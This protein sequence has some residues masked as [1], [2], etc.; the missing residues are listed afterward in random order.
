M[1]YAWDP[2]KAISNI[3]KHKVSFEEAQSVFDDPLATVFEDE[4]HS[5]I[6]VREFIIGHSHQ[7][8]LLLVWSEKIMKTINNSV[9]NSAGLKISDPDTISDELLPEYRFDYS[10]A[11]PNR[12]AAHQAQ[13]RT[14]E[15]A[16]DVAAVFT[17][18]EAVNAVLRALIQTMPQATHRETV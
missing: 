14:I 5:R 1:D 7:N 13:T 11:Q 2:A 18:Q 15:L 8:R 3:Q 16:P 10:K 12:F 9:V 17:S 4:E 6:E